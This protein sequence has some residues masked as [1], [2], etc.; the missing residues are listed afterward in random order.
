MSDFN[1]IKVKSKRSDELMNK[2]QELEIYRFKEL[3]NY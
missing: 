1:S 3:K 2:N